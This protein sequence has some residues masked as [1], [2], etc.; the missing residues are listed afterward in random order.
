MST[1]Y[2]YYLKF[3]PLDKYDTAEIIK[4]NE[5]DVRKVVTC[6]DAH[7]TLDLLPLQHDNL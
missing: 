2:V 7:K 1:K 3:N 4:T 6:Y 5:I